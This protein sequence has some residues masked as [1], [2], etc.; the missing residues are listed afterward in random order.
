MALPALVTP[1]AVELTQSL[2]DTALDITYAMFFLHVIIYPY[3]RDFHQKE[4]SLPWEFFYL[5]AWFVGTRESTMIYFGA[6]A[7]KAIHLLDKS[8]LDRVQN[9]DVNQ[10]LL[11]LHQESTGVDVFCHDVCI[12]RM[13]TSRRDGLLDD[14]CEVHWNINRDGLTD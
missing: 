6:E 10:Q 7:Y 2:V 3:C 9:L 12:L 1:R 8:E 14:V 4:G 13:N 11:L 5:D